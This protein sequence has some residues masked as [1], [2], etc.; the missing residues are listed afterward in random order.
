MRR[1]TLVA[2][3]LVA[4]ASSSQC[5]DGDATAI[6]PSSG[7]APAGPG[8]FANTGGGST[9]GDDSGATGGESGPG[10]ASS[11][12][13]LTLMLVTDRNGDGRPNRGDS[14]TFRI[15]TT[16]TW[17]QV[18]VVCSQNGTE[19]LRTEKTLDA[20]SPIPLTSQTWQAGQADCKATLEQLND[21]KVT[22][23][24]SATFTAGA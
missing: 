5:S 1:S 9:Q 20:W 24:A 16:Q 18:S 2:L 6:G 23:L 7:V 4:A 12:S 21:T 13:R 15:S 3:L 11:I 10:S 17:D 22:P 14:I 8:R 19:V